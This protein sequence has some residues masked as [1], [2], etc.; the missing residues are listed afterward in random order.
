MGNLRVLLEFGEEFTDIWVFVPC[1]WLPGCLGFDCYQKCG[2]GSTECPLPCRPQLPK[3][4][5]MTKNVGAIAQFAPCP[6]APS[7]Q[8][9]KKTTIPGNYR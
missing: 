5:N 1:T 9:N 8:K 6:V 7:S 4:S 3:W 2:C